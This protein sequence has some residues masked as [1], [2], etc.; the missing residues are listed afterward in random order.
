MCIL[1]QGIKSSTVCTTFNEPDVKSHLVS[2]TAVCLVEKFKSRFIRIL[3]TIAVE[4]LQVEKKRN[5]L[6]Y[7]NQSTALLSKYKVCQSLR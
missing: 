7:G 6:F 2:S 3:K 1:L 5:C 4:T